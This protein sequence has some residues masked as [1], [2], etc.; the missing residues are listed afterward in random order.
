[1]TKDESHKKSNP[2]TIPFCDA[3]AWQNPRNECDKKSC[4][5]HMRQSKSSFLEGAFDFLN[6]TIRVS[7]LARLKRD[8]SRG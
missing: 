5:R 3:A 7:F 2:K 1:M 8:A 4:S 6:I